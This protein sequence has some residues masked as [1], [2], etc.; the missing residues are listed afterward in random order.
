MM[1]YLK[2]NG[3]IIKT[4][5]FWFKKSDIFMLRSIP[6]FRSKINISLTNNSK[7]YIDKIAIRIKIKSRSGEESEEMIYSDKKLIAP[8]EKTTL[9]LSSYSMDLYDSIEEGSSQEIELIYIK[10][11]DGTEIYNEELL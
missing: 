6:I 7:F 4:D 2:I 1:E 5:D 10:M 3:Y 8:T 11:V 9:S